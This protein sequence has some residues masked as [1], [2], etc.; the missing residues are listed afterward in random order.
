MLLAAW[1]HSIKTF[2]PVEWLCT[3]LLAVSGI[4]WITTD[5]PLVNVVIG[6]TAHLLGATPTFIGVIRRPRSENLRFWL[7][8]AIASTL[9]LWTADKGD[10]KS[11]TYALYYFVF[12]WT[13]TVLTA[14]KYVGKSRVK[15]KFLQAN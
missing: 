7:L 3:A 5:A 9:A 11:F 10:I 13:M 6:L 8:F 1:R 12:E 4:V 15:P 2:G 14:R